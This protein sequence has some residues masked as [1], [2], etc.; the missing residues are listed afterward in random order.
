MQR[1]RQPFVLYIKRIEFHILR[2]SQHIDD[3]LEVFLALGCCAAVGVHIAAEVEFTAALFRDAIWAQDLLHDVLGVAR[4]EVKL[5]AVASLCRA[6]KE[7]AEGVV[8]YELQALNEIIDSL[9]GGHKGAGQVSDTD[10][11]SRKIIVEKSVE[12]LDEMLDTK[13]VGVVLGGSREARHM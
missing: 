5:D 9:F 3:A 7:V 4:G 1:K 8:T 13:L 2:K 6:G 11:M 10:L 12:T